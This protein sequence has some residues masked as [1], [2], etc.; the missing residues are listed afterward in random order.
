MAGILNLLPVRPV[1]MSLH[2][3]RAALQ[4]AIAGRPR[5]P[6][7]DG[8]SVTDSLGLTAVALVQFG[9][10]RIAQGAQ[11]AGG[12]S[13]GGEAVAAEQ[14]QGAVPERVWTGASDAWGR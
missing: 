4:P 1:R 11:G 2:R 8:P 9:R 12:G 5:G 7:A 10:V 6:L 13:G 14:V 3:V